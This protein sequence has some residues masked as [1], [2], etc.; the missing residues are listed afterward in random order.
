MR[1]IRIVSQWVFGILFLVLFL[2]TRYLGQD[3]IRYPVNAFFTV[4]P[5]AAGTSMAAGRQILGFFWPAL[6]I[7]AVTALFGRVFCGWICPMGGFLDLLGR[8]SR[9]LSPRPAGR[10]YLTKD[11]ILLAVLVGSLFAV[12]VSGI[13]DPLSLLIRTLT[14]GVVHPLEKGIHALFD[15]FWKT[16]GPVSAVSEPFYNFLSDH[17]LSFQLPMFRYTGLF[18]G[19]FLVVVLLE[20]SE[21]RFWCRNLCPLGALLGIVSA[22]NP[23]GLSVNRKGCTGCGSCPAACRMGAI[24]GENNQ[25][26]RKRDCVLCY[27]CVESC[28]DQLIAHRYLSEARKH[29]GPVF[30]LSR[31]AFLAAAGA[32]VFLPLAMGRTARPD[33]L[34]ATLIRPPGAVAE[35]RFLGLCLRCGECMRVCLTN[36][37]QPTLFEAGVEGLWTP[38][39][40]S[41][42]GYC[43]YSCTLCGQVCPTGAIKH[44]D[45]VTKRKVT[46]GKAVVDK[47]RCI[48]F[49]KPEQCIVCEEHCP[50]PEKAIVFDE[51]AVAGPDGEVIVKRPRVIDALCIGCGICETKCPVESDS[52]IIVVRDGEDR[53]KKEFEV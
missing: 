27:D 8:R 18:L 26:I 22:R 33:K 53:A 29:P 49:V 23:L 10:F 20:L 50:T 28:G 15:L 13:F 25:A 11:I 42:I 3:V 40:I 17:F 14:M 32:G 44:L 19:L 38:R 43:E 48:P 30:P 12:N 36:G 2:N 21:R 39:L 51:V 37:L 47:N 52:A 34:P 1:R 24:E 4:D 5:L 6:I 45:K 41:R 9:Q 35:D 16:G 31:R 7:L 46:I